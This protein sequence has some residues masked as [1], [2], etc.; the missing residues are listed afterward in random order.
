[1]IAQDAYIDW[2]DYPTQ[3][4]MEYEVRIGYMGKVEPFGAWHAVGNPEVIWMSKEQADA[5]VENTKQMMKLGYA[6]L[7]KKFE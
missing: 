4:E 1:M 3:P 6:N 7:L 5:F 2:D